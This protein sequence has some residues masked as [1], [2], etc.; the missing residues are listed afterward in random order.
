MASADGR[1]KLRIYFRCSLVGFVTGLFAGFLVSSLV[2]YFLSRPVSKVHHEPE[3]NTFRE[4]QGGSKEAIHTAHLLLNHTG[5]RQD[6]T[7]QWQGGPSLGRS[8]IYGFTLAQ[9]SLQTQRSGIYGVYV[10]MTLAQ[11]IQARGQGTELTEVKTLTIGILSA[12]GRHSSLLR[13]HFQGRCSLSASLQMNLSYQDTVYV[14]LTYPLMPSPNGDE[15]F[16]G[17][18]WLCPPPPAED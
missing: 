12:Q 7:L 5:S 4:K 11:C 9:G 16:F 13:R 10:Q 18:S 17:A 1:K 2:C 15:T 3:N 8:F 6:N 14:N